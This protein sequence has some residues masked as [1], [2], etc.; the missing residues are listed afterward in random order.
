MR[1]QKGR[2]AAIVLALV[3]G[4]TA[5]GLA[6]VAATVNP[7]YP[8]LSPLIVDSGVGNPWVTDGRD[9]GW[10]FFVDK[11]IKITHLGLFAMQRDA[12]GTLV[13][14]ALSTTHTMAVWRLPKEGGFEL[15]CTK[16]I[17]PEATIENHFAYA[18]LD[19]P[20]TILPDPVPTAA[21]NYERW[22]IGVW[23]GPSNH[24]LLYHGPIG[25][26]TL[27]AFQAGVIRLQ[28]Y[29]YYYKLVNYQQIYTSS[30]IV[31]PWGGTINDGYHYFA[32]NFKYDLL[33]PAANAGPDLPIYTCEQALTTISGVATHTVAGTA[34]Q[35]RWLEGSTVLK[36]WADVVGGQA[37]LSLAAP[38]PAFGVGDHALTLEVKD[39]SSTVS[40][41]MTLA[42]A[43]TPPEGQP[44][45][46]YQV[47]EIGTD[48]IIITASVADFDG[49]EVSYQW[50]KDGE[51]LDSGTITPLAGG[52]PA[53]IDDLVVQAGD[54]RFPL[55]SSEVQLVFGDTAN[56]AV[57]ETATVMMQDTTA[58]TVAPTSSLN[59]LWPPNQELIPITIWA[60]GADN[61]GGD[62][63]LTASVQ[64][65]ENDGLAESDWGIESI[66]STAGTI[67][68]CL[69]A[70]RA[71][72]GDG[73]VYTV[74]ITATDGSLNQS[75][76]TVDI[77]VP[78]DKRKK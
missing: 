25:A 70:E 74:T 18:P 50:V 67:A 7:A 36:D 48:A 8:G 52:G 46:T 60:N 61:G 54:P 68:L 34:M 33:G 6:G 73:R 53:E 11:P 30:T 45:P 71:G 14:S 57:T 47:L 31:E 64:C 19:E 22:L 65:S 40:D 27:D 76:A 43:N 13:D 78:H 15:R 26:L 9:Y 66:D 3:A 4:A 37:N 38:V 56:P 21:G 2:I 69:R 51:V 42:V 12:S 39:A 63:V 29:T 41:T 59:M 20:L 58:P 35:Y 55:G 17:G 23:T 24:E 5:P 32:L 16:T 10:R 77:R 44:T 62:L 72:S 49:D 1:A 75:V 28:A